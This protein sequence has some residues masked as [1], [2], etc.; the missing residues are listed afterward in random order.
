MLVL[1]SAQ[2]FGVCLVFALCFPFEHHF[3]FSIIIFHAQTASFD[4]RHFQVST[5]NH[6]LLICQFFLNCKIINYKNN[7]PKCV[8]IGQQPGMLANQITTSVATSEKGSSQK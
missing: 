2:I 4:R 5:H 3:L 7:Y 8:C 1:F 6:K